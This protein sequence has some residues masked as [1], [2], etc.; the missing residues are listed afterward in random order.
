MAGHHS[1]GHFLLDFLTGFENAPTFRRHDDET[2]RIAGAFCLT[3]KLRGDYDLLADFHRPV[4]D[5][6]NT[7]PYDKSQLIRFDK[8]RAGGGGQYEE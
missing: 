8:I 2:I 3:A 4:L 6:I 5:M 7:R 1:A